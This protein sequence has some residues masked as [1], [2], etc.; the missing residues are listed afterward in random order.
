[1]HPS[2]ARPICGTKQRS[3]HRAIDRA[4]DCAV[5]GS[6]KRARLKRLPRRELTGGPG[7]EVRG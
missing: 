6:I 5:D 2:V 4:V 1:M 7:Q 3:V